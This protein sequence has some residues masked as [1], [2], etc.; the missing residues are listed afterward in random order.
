LRE[1][2]EG[3][4]LIRVYCHGVPSDQQNN[5][6]AAYNESLVYRDGEFYHADTHLE[7][8]YHLHC[9]LFNIPV[10]ADDTETGAIEITKYL[11]GPISVPINGGG[12]TYETFAEQCVEIG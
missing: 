8:G 2:T 1:L 11:C 3:Y 5:D 6:I 10:T 9:Y 7:P 12:P 4:A